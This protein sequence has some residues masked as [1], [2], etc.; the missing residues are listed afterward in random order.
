[1]AKTLAILLLLTAFAAAS[2]DSGPPAL[3]ASTPLGTSQDKQEEKKAPPYRLDFDRVVLE[4]QGDELHLSL[5]ATSNLPR[6]TTLE[7]SIWPIVERYD[8]TKKILVGQPLD[9]PVLR[10]LRA[11]GIS[12][13]RVEFVTSERFPR[14]G[15]IRIDACFR[16]DRL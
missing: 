9:Q 10:K 3:A 4:K 14:D 7:F 5:R 11:E 1:M 15:E 16:P 2:F 6:E 12:G 8:K 13:G